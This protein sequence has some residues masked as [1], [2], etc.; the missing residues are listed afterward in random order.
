MCVLLLCSLQLSHKQ[1]VKAGQTVGLPLL[2]LED[3]L[4][5]LSQAEGACKMLGVKFASER[6]DAASRDRL[7]ASAAQSALPGMEVEGAERSSIQLHEAALSE[8]L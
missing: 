1:F 8:R 2:L 3:A 7:T 5:E 6:R 4:V